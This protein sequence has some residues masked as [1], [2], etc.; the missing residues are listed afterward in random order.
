MEI[1]QLRTL[2][3]VKLVF[4]LIELTMPPHVYKDAVVKLSDPNMHKNRVMFGYY[5]KAEGT[6]ILGCCGAYWEGHKYW[7][8]WTAVHPKQQRQGVG[9]LLL[10]KVLN[11][12]K[13][14]GAEE[15]YVE[16]YEHPEFRKAILFYWK[17]KFYLCGY[18]DKYL[19]DGS[20]ALLLKKNI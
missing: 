17:N 18:I 10:D 20:A 14:S 12:V 9:Q 6:D 4:P 8:S 16:T 13:K 3:E 2:E 19:S 1:K 7:V 15:I 11:Y 5:N